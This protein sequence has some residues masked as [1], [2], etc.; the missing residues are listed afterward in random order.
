MSFVVWIFADANRSSWR[1]RR[2]GAVSHIVKLLRYGAGLGNHGGIVTAVDAQG[3][4]RRHNQADGVGLNLNR[5]LECTGVLQQ[6]PGMEMMLLRLF[7]GRLQGHE[8]YRLP[9][10]SHDRLQRRVHSSGIRRVGRECSDDRAATALS[11]RRP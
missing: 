10:Q 4:R 6:M 9:Q 2:R 8:P 1:T 3:I 11:D 5:L 7:C